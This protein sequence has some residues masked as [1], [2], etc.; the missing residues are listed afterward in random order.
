MLKK[1]L[2]LIIFFIFLIN[3]SN[4][5]HFRGG[6]VSWEVV[7]PKATGSTVAVDITMRLFWNLQVFS[8]CDDNGDVAAG[9]LFGDS[10]NLASQS[11]PAWSISTLTNCYAY[12]TADLWSAG[13][14]TQRVYVTTSQ[15]V[16]GGWSSCCWVGGI[17][18]V[19]MSG[20]WNLQISIDLTTKIKGNLNSSPST[21][22][23]SWDILS[24]IFLIDAIV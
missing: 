3:K 11:G 2:H 10:G 19:D 8:N 17:I 7:D 20:Y 12:N 13:V 18:A 23:D 21:T 1:F 4:Q 14:R 22:V 24:V 5:S 16:T 9:N 6:T 15:A